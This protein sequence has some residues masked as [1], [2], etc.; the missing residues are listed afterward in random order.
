VDGQHAHAEP[1]GVRGRAT[2]LRGYVVELKIQE[3]GR[4]KADP[5]DHVRAGRREQR[6]A[7]LHERHQARQLLGQA[8]GLVREGEVSRYD[9]RVP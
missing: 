6:Q 5:T 4:M 3:Y 2:H 1:P 7:H 8:L 9:K